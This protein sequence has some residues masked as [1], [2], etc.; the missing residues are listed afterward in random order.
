MGRSTWY[1]KG[2]DGL[3]CGPTTQKVQQ[4]P[5]IGMHGAILGD[6]EI[7]GLASITHLNQ[8]DNAKI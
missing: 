1:G 8:I 5:T 4:D 2:G 7:H 6:W 3:D